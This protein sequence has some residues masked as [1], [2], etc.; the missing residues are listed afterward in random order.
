MGPREDSGVL[1]S[2]VLELRAG[3]LGV[4]VKICD[5]AH[6]LFCICDTLQYNVQKPKKKKKKPRRVWQPTKLELYKP[7]AFLWFLGPAGLP[8]LSCH[9]PPHPLT[10]RLGP[11]GVPD[12]CQTI[13]LLRLSLAGPSAWKALSMLLSRLPPSSS[14]FSTFGGSP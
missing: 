11:S 9:P 5:L 8:D 2:S 4:F 1:L 14:A 6:L 7:N 10:S 12:T 13:F 3:P